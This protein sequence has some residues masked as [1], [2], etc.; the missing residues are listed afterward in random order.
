MMK[1]AFWLVG[2]TCSGKSTYAEI[3]AKALET[4]VKYLDV[5]ADKIELEGMSREE[6]YCDIFKDKKDILVVEGIVPFNFP[7]DME[8]V[9]RHLVEYEVIYILV[10]PEYQEWLKRRDTRKAEIPTSEPP[11]M[12]EEEYKKY[13][14][15]LRGRLRRFLEVRNKE[16]L[17]IIS[18]EQIRNLRYQHEGFTDTKWKQLLVDVKSKRV[19]DLGC[20]AC[21]FES[22]A[23]ENGAKRYLGLDI[24][25]SYLIRKN[26]V[27]FDLNKLEEWQDL[28]DI[29]I[30]T[31]VM[32]YIHDKEKFIR[33][34][35][36]ITE[37]L[38]VLEIP[39]DKGDGI[40]LHL[41]SRG[42]YFPTRK[43]F[44]SW[45]EKYFA[46]FRCVGQ[47]I[48]EDGSFRLIYHCKK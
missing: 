28:F 26:A 35:A 4:D 31:S 8:Y 1:I 17:E 44:E 37:E 10:A 21:Q 34:C 27:L 33:E 12:T 30:C 13:N 47:S 41:G 14:K 16:D 38:C 18:M 23:I 2:A 29:V 9:S 5:I 15:K 45:L 39:L 24:N 19:L 46:S 3:V 7:L 22:F 20:S 36:R 40:E 25:F 11:F 6:G 32:H 43:L 48:V 42:L